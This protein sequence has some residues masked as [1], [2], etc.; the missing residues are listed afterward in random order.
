MEHHI[1]TAGALTFVRSR[2]LLSERLKVARAELDHM[3]ELVII[4]PSKYVWSFPLH[5]VP[6]VPP[7]DWRPCGD[8]R[9]LN[10]ASLPDRYHLPYILD[11][12]SHLHDCSILLKIDLVRAY[13]QI[14]VITHFGLFEFLRMPYG[15][16]NADQTF[17]RFIDYVLRGLPFCWA[18]L[19]DL[20]IASSSL[21]PQTASSCSLIKTAGIW[22]QDEL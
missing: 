4:R 15:L 14:P 22:H 13:H 1:E 6:K 11:F 20:L 7:G 21:A 17:Q 18:Y 8:Y 5:L 19:D 9:V 3:F 16:R 12:T 10:A 2:R